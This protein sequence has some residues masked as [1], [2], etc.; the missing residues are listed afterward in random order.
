[1]IKKSLG[2]VAVGFILCSI[3]FLSC[4]KINEAT[5]LGS[6]LIPSVDN[7]NTFEL[8]LE[9]ETDNK[10]FP[11]KTSLVA[12]DVVA[13]GSFN[14]PEFGQTEASAYFTM[15]SGVYSTYPFVSKEA[16]ITIDSVILS[17]GYASG[18][19]DTIGNQTIEVFDLSP[20]KSFN[21]TAFYKY[22]DDE[23]SSTGAPLGSKSFSISALK[24]AVQVIYKKD[25]Q[26]L[27]NVLRIPLA[28]SLGTRLAS[29]DISL[30]TNGGYYNDS[31]FK[32]LFKGFAVKGAGVGTALTYFNLFDTAKSKLVVYFR[33]TK[34]G[35]T[36]TSS[37]SFYHS[38]LQNGGR[39]VPGGVANTIKRTPGG[40]WASYLSNGMPTD[41]KLYIQSSPGSF[42][43]IKIPGLDNM[44]NRLIHLAELVMYRVPSAQANIF[45]APPLLY[46]DRINAAGDSAYL[47]ESDQTVNN[48]GSINYLGGNLKGDTI[49]FN[50]TRHVQGIVTRKESNL[51]LRLYAP[52]RTS[53]YLKRP[54]VDTNAFP[55]AA[56]DKIA[57]G[58]IVLGGGN[59]ADPNLRLRLRLVY[60][61]L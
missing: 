35:K 19:G 27:T 38:A 11:E 52:L 57:N 23:F 36:D 6:D 20:A 33:A 14:D 45:T 30:A 9:T 7:V 37:A 50:I 16:A 29:Y 26:N 40:N 25:T 22:S 60:S 15:S 48:D 44:S 28:N 5:E 24:N 43:K 3:I 61:N 10:P 39:V 31:L 47:F 54:A 41:D 51:D 56:S 46:L 34:D 17:L 53:L 32:T 58:R 1:M 2:L 13:V 8:S 42:A 18:Y 59:Y 21:D 49:R 4:K 55:V 12:G